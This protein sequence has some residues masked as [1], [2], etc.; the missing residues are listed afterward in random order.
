MIENIN[1]NALPLLR[2]S[3]S[4]DN[5]RWLFDNSLTFLPEN[6]FHDLTTLAYL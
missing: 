2:S 3:R 4:V 1:T 5:L 6:I